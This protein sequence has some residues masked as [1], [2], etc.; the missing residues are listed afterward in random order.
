MPGKEGQDGDVV[1]FERLNRNGR[2]VRMQ[3]HTPPPL[4][5]CGEIIVDNRTCAFVLCPAPLSSPALLLSGYW[6]WTSHPPTP[7]SV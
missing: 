4:G 5:S 1:V 6:F 3:S 7:S 2:K